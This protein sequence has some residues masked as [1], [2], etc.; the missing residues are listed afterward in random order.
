MARTLVLPFLDSRVP[1]AA[2]ALLPCPPRNTPGP[3]WHHS[4]HPCAESSEV[5]AVPTL[6][7]ARQV[8]F[9]E[10]TCTFH[11]LPLCEFVLPVGSPSLPRGP[12]GHSSIRMCPR[13]LLTPGLV[14]SSPAAL[15][16]SSAGSWCSGRMLCAGRGAWEPLPDP[17][18]TCPRLVPA[19][20]W[21]TPHG[22]G[23]ACSV[24]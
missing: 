10:H 16:S 21:L 2:R 18:Q 1:F 23:H 15:R 3:S 11:S 20:T 19:W 6:C 8:P 17:Q 22:R 24:S 4:G 5:T 14:L 7:L 12:R 13:P 9:P